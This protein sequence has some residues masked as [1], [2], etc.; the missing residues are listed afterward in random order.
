MRYF[1]DLQYDGAAYCGWQRQPDATTVQGVIEEKLSM[2]LRAD[3]EI[4]GAGR[5]DTGVNASY[6]VAHFDTDV[7][8]DTQ[9]LRYKLNKVLPPDIAILRIREVGPTLHA[10]FDAREREYTYFLLKNFNYS[11]LGSTSSIA[12]AVKPDVL[13]LDEVLSVGDAAF[14][15]KSEQRIMD[16]MADGVT[17]LYV[18][19]ST[20]RV[21]KLC[22]KAIILT[23]GQVVAY[24][25]SDEICDMYNEM[26]T[27][28]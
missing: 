28:K 13:I 27:S 9:Q 12:T 11:K 5:T 2:L 10:R 21:R 23:R 22:N 3:T 14:K 16:M 6:Y 1:I 4:V 7:A 8:L 19:H 24:G 26:V 20:E 15:E 18:S 25:D 17:V